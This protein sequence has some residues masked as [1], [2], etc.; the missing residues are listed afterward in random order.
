MDSTT[1]RI[2]W[3]C[4]CQP[5][6]RCRPSIPMRHEST[7]RSSVASRIYRLIAKMPTLAALAYRHSMGLPY[8]YPDNDLSFPA[9]S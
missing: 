3:E 5:L 9:T 1:T 4:C 2:P 6:A 8:N 7:T